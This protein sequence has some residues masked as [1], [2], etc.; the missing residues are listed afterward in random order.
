MGNAKLERGK[1]RNSN[2]FPLSILHF[3]F[4]NFFCHKIFGDGVLLMSA[5]NKHILQ[6]ELLCQIFQKLYSVHS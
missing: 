3:S 6:G 2:N 5:V 1:L 4:L